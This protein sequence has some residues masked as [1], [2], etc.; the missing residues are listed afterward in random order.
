MKASEAMFFCAGNVSYKD[1]VYYNICAVARYHYNGD[2]F[3]RH[4]GRSH[5]YAVYVPIV[6]GK[7]FELC[8][9]THGDKYKMPNATVCIRFGIYDLVNGAPIESVQVKQA[10]TTRYM[11]WDKFDWDVL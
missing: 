6:A 3:F 1:A 4:I 10:G 9:E 5:Y 7:D 2:K 11:D 8:Y